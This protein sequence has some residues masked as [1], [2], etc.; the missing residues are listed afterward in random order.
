MS[1][2]PLETLN[3][4]SK[5][6]RLAELQ[7]EVVSL[8][9]QVE[10]STAEVQR[11]EGELVGARNKDLADGARAIRASRTAPSSTAEPKVQKKLDAAKRNRD[12]LAKA[13][14]DARSD[15]GALRAKHQ[16]AL[17]EDVRQARQKIAAEVAEAAARALQGF[18]RYSDLHYLLKDLAPP[19]PATD[20]QA[21]AQRLTQTF[22]GLHT[23]TSDGPARGEVEGVLQYLISLA[24][25]E[26]QGE[27]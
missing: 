15:L 21:P 7:Q 2:I 25:D 19:P 6:P 18:S 14:E 9:R 22:V 4:K 16:H 11:L 24:P 12:V 17:F 3:L 23:T 1:E 10:R 5:W 8:E 26:A 20:E 13:L 27:G